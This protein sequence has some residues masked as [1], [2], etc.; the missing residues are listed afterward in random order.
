V[1]N[2]VSFLTWFIPDFVDELKKKSLLGE[3]KRRNPFSKLSQG[4][5]AYWVLSTWDVSELRTQETNNSV[6]HFLP[7]PSIY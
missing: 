7:N 6:G 3:A 5:F 2:R 4:G 1:G